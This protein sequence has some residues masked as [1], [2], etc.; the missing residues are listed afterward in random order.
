MSRKTNG[1]NETRPEFRDGIHTN[2]FSF[3]NEENAYGLITLRQGLYETITFFFSQFQEEPFD[4]GE[5]GGEPFED[6]FISKILCYDCHSLGCQ[7]V[8]A[9]Y[10]IIQI[11]QLE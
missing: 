2:R 11:F 10:F 4:P 7:P 9:Q 1:T 3:F 6:N 8:D 5:I